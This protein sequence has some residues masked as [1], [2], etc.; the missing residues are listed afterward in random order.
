MI[1]LKNTSESLL[2]YRL[3]GRL[4]TIP[5]FQMTFEPLSLK[6]NKQSQWSHFY[7]ISV[8]VNDLSV[9][10]CNGTVNLFT[11]QSLGTQHHVSPT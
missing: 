5:Q 6:V 2:R 11:K 4:K 3:S 7:Q 9:V 8:K 1:L 10:L